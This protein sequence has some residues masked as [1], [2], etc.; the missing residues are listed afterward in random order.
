MGMYKTKNY[1]QKYTIVNFF[2]PYPAT[3]TYPELDKSSLKDTF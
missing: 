1:A 3:G 2:M